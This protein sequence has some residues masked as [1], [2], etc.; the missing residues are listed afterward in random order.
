ME[1]GLHYIQL[2]AE[3]KQ[4]IYSISE[5]EQSLAEIYIKA[6]II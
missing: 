4:D 5:A 1:P 2:A 3:S 6:I